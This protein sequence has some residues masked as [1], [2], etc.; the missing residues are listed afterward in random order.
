MKEIFDWLLGLV[1]FALSPHLWVRAFQAIKAKR[2]YKQA[3]KDA[4]FKKEESEF[5]KKLQ[6]TMPGDLIEYSST[7]ILRDPFFKFY[8]AIPKTRSLGD[9]LSML[10]ALYSGADK[11]ILY[12]PYGN[13]K[14][15]LQHD[16][17]D[18]LLTFT[19]WDGERFA[20][21]N[22]KRQV[23]VRMDEQAFLDLFEA[24]YI[25]LYENKEKGEF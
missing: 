17:P 21:T 25:D 12:T 16:Y 18:T 2:A 3:E 9:T 14:I 11:G 13:V 10:S 15:D 1:Y 8:H 6:D 20:R 23:F 22:V 24:L 19:M 5:I 4:K 7:Q